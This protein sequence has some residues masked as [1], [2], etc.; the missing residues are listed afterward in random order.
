MA[1]V[2]A[3]AVI[4]AWDAGDQEALAEAVATL[5]QVAPDPTPA[6]YDPRPYITSPGVVFAKPMP[7]S[8]HFYVQIARSTDWV[9]HLQ[10][11]TWI[12]QRGQLER[13]QGRQYRYVILDKWRYWALGVEHSIIN[14]REEPRAGVGVGTAGTRG[15]GV[16]AAIYTRISEDTEGE[17]PGR[18]PP[19]RAT[20][21]S[22]A[23]ASGWSKVIEARPA[24]TRTTTSRAFSGKPRP[25]YLRLR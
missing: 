21:G 15:T 23:S 2:T 4:D 22:C 12:R 10:C 3:R 9:G 16:R 13:F 17:G 25:E 18:G 5:R 11:L 19:E 6:D 20:A 14:R 24:S 7:T 8:P 1:L